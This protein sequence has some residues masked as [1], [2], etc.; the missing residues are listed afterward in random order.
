MDMSAYGKP[1]HD[2][3]KYISLANDNKSFV[4]GQDFWV[5]ENI[6]MLRSLI[7]T[8]LLVFWAYWSSFGFSF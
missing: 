7:D 8:M 1:K 2:L 4:V 3:S 6:H 5:E